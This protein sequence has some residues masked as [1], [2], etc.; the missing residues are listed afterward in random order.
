MLEHSSKS[1]T[2]HNPYGKRHLSLYL[3]KKDATM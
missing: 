3:E 2:K 1:T